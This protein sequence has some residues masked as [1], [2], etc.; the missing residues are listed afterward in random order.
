MAE[1]KVSQLFKTLPKTV[2]LNTVKTWLWS[3][4]DST[5][6]VTRFITFTIELSEHLLVADPTERAPIYKVCTWPSVSVLQ[7]QQYLC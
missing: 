4:R 2:T 3:K 1:A 6:V 5:Y 7:M